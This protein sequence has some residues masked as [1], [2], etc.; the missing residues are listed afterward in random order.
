MK[1]RYIG[2][3][4]ISGKDVHVGDAFEYGDCLYI[5]YEDEDGEVFVRQ[6]ENQVQYGVDMDAKYIERLPMRL[7]DMQFE[8]SPIIGDCENDET[9]KELYNSEMDIVED[10]PDE[11]DEDDEY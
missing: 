7:E 6:F 11:Y 3:K 10:E 8:L 1:R 2:K 4:D 5:V 9:I